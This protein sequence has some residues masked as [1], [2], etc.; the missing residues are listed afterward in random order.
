L[1]RNI[2]KSNLRTWGI[3]EAGN[4][5]VQMKKYVY[6]SIFSHGMANPGHE[7]GGLLL[8]NVSKYGGKYWVNI[9]GLARADSAPASQS[10]V[11]FTSDV[12]RQLVESAQRN[13]PNQRVVGWYHTHP[14]LGMFFSDDDVNSHRVAFSNPWHVAAVCDPVRNEF[15]FFGWDSSEIKALKGFYT[16]E[17]T[18]EAATTPSQSTP[19]PPQQTNRTAAILVPALTILLAGFA[20]VAVLIMGKPPPSTNIPTT[21]YPYTSVQTAD[22][23][24]GDAVATGKRPEPNTGKQ[25]FYLIDGRSGQVFLITEE[26]GKMP[27]VS[28]EKPL[29]TGS[30]PLTGITTAYA[31]DLSKAETTTFTIKG[32]DSAGRS[33]SF[34]AKIDPAGRI[35]TEW[36]EA[37]Q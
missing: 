27:Q 6:D 36:R 21:Q 5:I 12:W 3:P 9:V 34:Q 26:S 4:I 24:D 32:I 33:R 16:Y 30:L 13:Y 23:Q 15:G 22:L 31:P 19:R 28:R 10:Q 20:G 37:N 18:T 17:P 35:K 11:Q 8:G 2:A 7:V 29:P 14:N 25:Y 1:S